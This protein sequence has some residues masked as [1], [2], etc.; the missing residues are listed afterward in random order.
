MGNRNEKTHE[1][2]AKI[3]AAARREFA[4][5]GFAGART[6][7]IAREAGFNKAMLH[8]YFGSKKNLYHEI[9]KS[10][11]SMRKV[12]DTM[13]SLLMNLDMTS[14]QRLAAAIYFMVHQQLLCFDPEF[15]SILNWE[16][17]EGRSNLKEIALEFIVPR[18]KRF[19]AIIQ[20][21]CDKGD[22]KCENT[23][24]FVWGLISR[25]IFYVMQRDI[26]RDTEIFDRLYR[27]LS[28]SEIVRLISIDSLRALRVP[29]ESISLRFPETVK[30][31]ID[32][33]INGM[34]A[35][36]EKTE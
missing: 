26:Y 30:K 6:E 36:N 20:E 23:L 19:E 18:I 16:H 34:S 14:Q 15:H 31:E 25:V 3:L 32:T 35:K 28:V 11:F 22:F 1:S 17:A 9:L 29:E 4:E 2:K 33:I 5:R 24:F 8:Y 21:G 10:M 27:N 12:D 13:S 7:K